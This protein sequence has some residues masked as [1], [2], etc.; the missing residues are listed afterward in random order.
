MFN[1]YHFI[2]IAI[3]TSTCTR[4]HIHQQ[5]NDPIASSHIID[6]Q[7]AIFKMAVGVGTDNNYKKL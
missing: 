6:E 1:V 4:F 7:T 2:A 3:Q 5:T